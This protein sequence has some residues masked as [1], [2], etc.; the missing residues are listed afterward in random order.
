MTTP[1]VHSLSPSLSSLT[2][3]TEKF[4][5]KRKEKP[6]IMPSSVS[7]A[8]PATHF[9]MLT[10]RFPPPTAPPSTPAHKSSPELVDTPIQPPPTKRGL[11]TTEQDSINVCELFD[12]F[13]SGDE[14]LVPML[15]LES[16][17][18]PEDSGVGMSLDV[19]P[20]NSKDCRRGSENAT[21]TSSNWSSNTGGWSG[22][23]STPIQYSAK[24]RTTTPMSLKRSVQ[25]S[26][27]ETS[28]MTSLTAPKRPSL[29]PR[30]LV[31]TFRTVLA[32][33][34][35]LMDPTTGQPKI[36]YT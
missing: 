35:A 2:S 9:S 5:Y 10:T 16:D 8:P 18:H 27:K 25:S 19:S 6:T 12:N 4:S 36:S 20:F 26:A 34:C 24:V 11:P 7:S 17:Q 28:F 31:P 23:S 21:S 3:L 15:N 22:N 33:E 32:G 1:T 29:Q 14:I 30:N 13:D